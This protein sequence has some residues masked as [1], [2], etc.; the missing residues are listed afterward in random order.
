MDPNVKNE[1]LGYLRL[2][3]KIS[4]MVVFEGEGSGSVQ[5]KDEKKQKSIGCRVWTNV[6]T[7]TLL[8]GHNLPAMDQNGKQAQS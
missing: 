3:I 7:V 4:S 1:N 8:E 2:C 6:L 5:S